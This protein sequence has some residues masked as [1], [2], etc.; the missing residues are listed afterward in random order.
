MLPTANQI[1]AAVGCARVVAQNISEPMRETCRVYDI[2]TGPR[3]AAFLAQ[4]GHESAS[5]TR[6]RENLNYSAD[7][8]MRTW[9]S[10]FTRALAE[11]VARKPEHI[12]NIAYGGRLGNK[13][14]GDGWRYIGRGWTQVT[15]LANYEAITALVHEKV[16]TVPDFTLHP[17]LLESPRWAALS[18][19]AYWN[20]HELN[21]L[22][23]KGDFA[24][25]T[26][27][28]NGGTIGSADR[29]ARYARAMRVFAS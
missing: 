21:E 15:G 7:G 13:N 2:D 27:R 1:E 10:R 29:N 19:G 24:R 11:Q 3:V 20:D 18:A 26:K 17:E 14:P 22:A 28:I 25:I 23:D 4:T 5:F 16:P 6:T 9:P 8:L 12:A